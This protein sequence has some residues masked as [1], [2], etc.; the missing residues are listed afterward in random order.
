MVNLSLY[1][2]NVLSDATLS[3]SEQATLSSPTFLADDQLSYKM[4]AT[5]THSLIKIDQ[6]GS[7]IDPFRYM[8]LVDHTMAGGE[9]VVRTFPTVD[10]VTPTV[11]LSGT[12]TGEDPNV[13]D[14]G[15]VPTNTQFIDVEL[16]T[17]GGVQLSVGELMLASLFDSPQFPAP[18]INTRY[19]PRRTPIDLANGERLSIKHA[20]TIREKSYSIPSLTF[21]EA[22]E[23]VDLFT[24]NEGSE[25]IVL[26]DDEGNTYPALMNQ[27]LEANTI[28]RRVTIGLL[29]SEIK[30]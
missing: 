30:L 27:I 21:A 18:G 9:A 26:I 6:T 14:F 1:H 23:W 2:D 20:E 13:T 4:T 19:I 5:G 29:F 7:A 8:I 3:G 28:A 12:L 25:L 16:T 24:E 17:S 15:S 11:V 10:R 22:A